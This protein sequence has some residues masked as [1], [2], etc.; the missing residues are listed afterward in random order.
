MCTHTNPYPHVQFL[1]FE[2]SE[3]EG[4]YSLIVSVCAC[5]LCVWG[6]LFVCCMWKHYVVCLYC[7]HGRFSI[8][9]GTGGQGGPWPPHFFKADTPTLTFNMLSK[10]T[11]TCP[12]CTNL[13]SVLS[14]NCYFHCCSACHRLF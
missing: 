14:Q 12:V 11:E 5:M 9:G 2:R 3:L 1:S 7:M 8:G 4:K 10:N 13:L 6:M